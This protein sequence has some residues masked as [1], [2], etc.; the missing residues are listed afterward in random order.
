MYATPIGSHIRV[1]EMARPQPLVSNC[2]GDMNNG[3]DMRRS[4]PVQQ[5]VPFSQM[6]SDYQACYF[7]SPQQP[8]HQYR[9]DD[10]LTNGNSALLMGYGGIYLGRDLL[11]IL[12]SSSS[13]SSPAGSGN[14]NTETPLRLGSAILRSTSQKNIQPQQTHLAQVPL[15]PPPAP[16]VNNI[17][18]NNF[19][20]NVI[21]NLSDL[22]QS[23]YHPSHQ[24]Q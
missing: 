18:I 17:I 14:K 8:S 16:T 2:V 11:S 6:R 3:I 13:S 7:T 21:K 1:E 20:G 12:E 19:N 24:Q 9:E 5:Q 15:P 4:P 22:E 10:L 23:N